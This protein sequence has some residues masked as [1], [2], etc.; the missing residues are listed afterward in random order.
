MASSPT[1][2]TVRDVALR[3]GVSPATVSYVLNG[4]RSGASRISE[5]TRSR[6]LAAT[7]ELGYA[8]NHA[9]RS[10]RRR[11]TERI[12]LVVSR[13]GSP[14]GE[15]M[16]EDIQRIAFGH[17]YS[18]VVAVAG[19]PER[20]R[21]IVDQLR[22]RLADGVVDTAGLDQ[23]SLAV[24]AAANVAVV[25]LGN[26]LS[27][28][29][30]DVVRTTEGAACYDAVAHLLDLGHRRVAFVGH[31]GEEERLASYRR[32]HGDRDL[33]PDARLVRAGAADRAEAYQSAVDLLALAE[34]P[35]AVFAASDIAAIS[36]IWA[37]RDA[38]R[39]VPDDLAVV[40]VGNVPEGQIM[41][42]P[43]SSVGPDS[44]DFGDIAAL[45]TS[46]LAGDAP[47]EGRVMVRP[48]SFFPRGT[49]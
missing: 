17:G 21:Q 38:G 2:P 40:G 49:A 15:L 36:A 13:L 5:G 9:A 45:L 8:P 18:T 12:C 34:P 37:A 43:L 31:G 20:E 16:A 25:A 26:H 22:R 27:P 33:A 24:L 47:A 32:A 29:G 11:C 44:M 28:D 35:S 1:A 10:L 19:S 14:Y 4:R 3:S 7:A 42:P 48:W 46:R 23:R 41:R 30:F 39:R 6:V